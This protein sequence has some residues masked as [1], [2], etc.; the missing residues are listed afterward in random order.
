MHEL[1]FKHYFLSEKDRESLEECVLEEMPKLQGK[2]YEFDDEEL[3]DIV[4]NK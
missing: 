4:N 2:V 1:K 3:M